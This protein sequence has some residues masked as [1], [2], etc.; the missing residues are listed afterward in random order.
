MTAPHGS[1]Q[2]ISLRADVLVLGGGPAATWAA[3]SA[4]RAGAAVVL[5]D[6][7][8]CGTSGAAAASNNNV[9]YVKDPAEY[10][11]HFTE[12]FR[13]GGGLSERGW[14]EAVLERAVSDMQ[15]V[16]AQRVRA[17]ERQRLDRLA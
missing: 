13:S 5:A 3:L 15:D 1:T 2:D 14:T 7:G 4:A 12:R 16:S 9:W 6:K 10:E 11:R 8:Y 17:S